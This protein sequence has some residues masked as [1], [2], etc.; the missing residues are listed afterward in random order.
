MLAEHPCTLWDASL[1]CLPSSLTWCPSVH[2][3]KHVYSY[4]SSIKHRECTETIG[5]GIFLYRNR[6]K[7]EMLV[8]FHTRFT[9]VWTSMWK[10]RAPKSV[11]DKW[12][13]WMLR[14]GWRT[15]LVMPKST[16]LVLASTR[17]VGELDTVNG[18]QGL[19]LYFPVSCWVTWGQVSFCKCVLIYLVSKIRSPFHLGWLKGASRRGFWCFGLVLQAPVQCIHLK[20]IS[21]SSLFLPANRNLWNPKC[22]AVLNRYHTLS[23]QAMFGTAPCLLPSALSCSWPSQGKPQLTAQRKC[24]VW[25]TNK[26]FVRDCSGLS[27]GSTCLQ[28]VWQSWGLANVV[29]FLAAMS[30]KSELRKGCGR[31]VLCPCPQAWCRWAVPAGPAAIQTPP[32]R[33][34]SPITGHR[35]TS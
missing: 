23:E 24:T 17:T 19:M 6:E 27:R 21:L 29:L 33:A 13:F 22:L 15:C 16:M 1:L 28:R 7:K 18:N 35:L 25:A 10:T 3:G 8:G 34:W 32:A 9:P 31:P 5:H 14:K 26:A 30:Y 20:T 11:P 2:D 12:S 4:G